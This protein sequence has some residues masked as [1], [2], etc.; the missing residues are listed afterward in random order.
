MESELKVF[1]QKDQVTATDYVPLLDETLYG[2]IG[3]GLVRSGSNPGMCYLLNL[4]DEELTKYRIGG[5]TGYDLPSKVLATKNLDERYEIAYEFLKFI[6]QEYLSDDLNFPANLDP[7]YLYYEDRALRNRVHV[8]STML[9]L[10]LLD[11]LIS[12]PMRIEPWASPQRNAAG[13]IPDLRSTVHEAASI[14][15]YILHCAQFPDFA[16]LN[17]ERC[18][19]QIFLKCWNISADPYASFGYLKRQMKTYIMRNKLPVKEYMIWSRNYDRIHQAAVREAKKSLGPFYGMWL[20]TFGGREMVYWSEFKAKLGTP[21]SPK[22]DMLQKQLTTGTRKITAERFGHF[23]YSFGK[24]GKT[25]IF[26]EL[27]EIWNDALEIVNSNLFADDLLGLNYREVLASIYVNQRI[28]PNAIG[29]V[30]RF[31]SRNRRVALTLCFK[32]RDGSICT[33]T[34]P[35]P[36]NHR[37]IKYLRD[38]LSDEISNPYESVRRLINANDENT[39]ALWDE[40]F[41]DWNKPTKIVRFS[42]ETILAAL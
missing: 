18:D 1:L 25:N 21:S 12:K 34:H 7:R 33:S 13:F 15:W 20:R 31:D 41:D 30:I 32:K 37:P 2:N 10:D 19:Y 6:S 27:H 24:V 9:E 22:E 8:S 14:T 36:L 3:L 11:G 28:K 23:C 17:H 38:L 42:R 35:A 39:L 4:M 40:Q 29:V 5:A 16:T 26:Y